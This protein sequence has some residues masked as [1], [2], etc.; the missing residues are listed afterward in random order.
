MIAGRLEIEMLANMARLADDMKQ[1]RGM[2]GGA[3]KD[4]EKSVA[5]A[6]NALGALGVGL[7]IDAFASMIKGSIDAADKLGDLSK[8][9]DMSVRDMAGLSLLA[10]QNGTDLDGLAKGIQKMSVEMGKDPEKFKALGITADT[11]KEAFMQFADVFSKLTDINQ[12]NALS[13]A[14]FGKS[15]AE[16]APVLSE[17]S[18]KIGQTIE[19]GA[20]LSGMTEQMTER[21]DKFNDQMA[22]LDVL[23]KRTGLAIADFLLP[24]MLETSK[25]MSEL[26]ENG[27]PVLALWR[28]LAGIGKVPWDLLLPPEDLKKSLSVDK[29]LSDLVGQLSVIEDKIKRSQGTGLLHRWM[30]GSVDELKQ[31]ATNLKNQI[32]T[33]KKHRAEL[34]RTEVIPAVGKVGNDSSRAQAFLDADKIAAAAKKAREDAI[35]EEQRKREALAS[36]QSN[37]LDDWLKFNQ[38]MQEAKDQAGLTDEQR[39]GYQWSKTLED[40]ER[41]KVLLQDYGMWSVAREQEYNDA[42]VNSAGVASAAMIKL[43]ENEARAKEATLTGALGSISSLM[44]SKNKELFALGKAAAIANSTIAML[45]GATR[46]MEYPF[47]GPALAAAVMAAGM[48]NIVQIAST[49]IGGGAASPT[50][51]TLG[52]GGSATPT[53]VYGG[54][55]G[56]PSTPTS[57]NNDQTISVQTNFTIDAPGADAGVEARIRNMMPEL[58]AANRNTVYS[59]VNQVMN[60]RGKAL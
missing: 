49:Q 47:I 8:A 18:K 17:G 54:N 46:A 21:A 60:S 39:I 1:A 35:K 26:A 27:H 20:Q 23:S 5:L 31:G 32:D 3:M 33:I 51:A 14:V 11:N 30:Y 7:S 10:K 58:I 42:K 13:S 37:T 9:T 36:L 41:R 45:S 38:Q 43:A 50:N 53:P 40:I 29:Q 34:E 24:N 25:A 59:A 57:Q 56:G 2:V 6:K 52:G 4:I 28:G 12:R 19:K 22:E 16:L 48:A 44:S 55:P 15:W